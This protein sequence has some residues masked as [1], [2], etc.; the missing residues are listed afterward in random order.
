MARNQQLSSATEE[1]IQAFD[2]LD[3]RELGVEK[4]VHLCVVLDAGRRA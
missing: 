1:A 2:T 4:E 3:R